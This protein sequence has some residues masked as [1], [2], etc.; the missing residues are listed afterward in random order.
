MVLRIDK[1]TRL[2]EIQTS[3]TGEFPYLKLEFYTQPHGPNQNTIKKN[4]RG[5][6]E[7]ALTSDKRDLMT[8]IVFDDNWKVFEVEGIF[9][10][11][12]GLFAQV[13]RKSGSVWIETSLTDDWTLGQQN[14]EGELL[15]SI[16]L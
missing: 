16:L 1:N 7:L 4:M 2:V 14:K 6:G 10:E 15:S 5:S 8:E 3:F 12:A 11:K 13:F 9:S